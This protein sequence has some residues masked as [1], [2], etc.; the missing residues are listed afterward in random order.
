MRRVERRAYCDA[1]TFGAL[2]SHNDGLFAHCAAHLRQRFAHV[3]RN[4]GSE[5]HGLYLPQ[6][7]QSHRGVDFVLRQDNRLRA[8]TLDDRTDEGA[9]LRTGKKYGHVASAAR[10]VEAFA[11]GLDELLELRRRHGELT[12][13][14]LSDN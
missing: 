1:A 12:I 10:F 8:K 6:R 11:H 3:F 4:K 9:D 2:A 5:L 14:A 7:S 13:L